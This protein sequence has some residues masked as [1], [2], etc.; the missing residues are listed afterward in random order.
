MNKH[1]TMMFVKKKSN[2]NKKQTPPCLQ[3]VQGSAL[4][5]CTIAGES[6]TLLKVMLTV[7]H[8]TTKNPAP[9][10]QCEEQVQP[11]KSCLWQIVACTKGFPKP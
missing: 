6:H 4:Y 1:F 2:N 10:M 3:L 7:Q 11:H 5:R 8:H 9:F